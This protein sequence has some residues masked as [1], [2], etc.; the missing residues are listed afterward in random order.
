MRRILMALVL[1]ALPAAGVHAAGN[2]PPRSAIGTDKECI[3][4]HPAQFKQWQ[5]S[6]HA[7]KKP[8]AGC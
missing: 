2:P 3:Q 5:A 8:V 7:K 6:A 4:C 1:F